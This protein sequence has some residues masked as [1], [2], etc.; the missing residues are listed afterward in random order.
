MTAVEVDPGALPRIAAVSDVAR[1]AEWQPRG[2]VQSIADA[3]TALLE[4]ARAG[5]VSTTARGGQWLMLRIEE[6]LRGF[7]DIRQMAFDDPPF[8]YHG[9]GEAIG[10]DSGEATTS[11][12]A[13]AVSSPLGA[14]P[15]FRLH[16]KER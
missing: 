7:D 16:K 11:R 15:F 1:A 4:D 8:T 14:R 9:R 6:A 5:R 2:N 3:L 10:G 13:P 12:S